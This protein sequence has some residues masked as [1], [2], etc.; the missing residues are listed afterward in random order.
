MEQTS[1]KESLKQSIIKFNNWVRNNKIPLSEA[2]VRHYELSNEFV[3]A[4]RKD[5]GYFPYSS[6]EITSLPSGLENYSMGAYHPVKYANLKEGEVVLD[7]GCG[8]GIDVFLAANRVGKSGKVIGVDVTF[9][10]LKRAK[11][12]ATG[13]YS[14]LTF[15]INASGDDLPVADRSVDAIISNGV[16]HLIQ[17]K[18]KAFTEF[19][20]VLRPHGRAVIS[21]V[22][23]E[24][25]IVG[26]FYENPT[27]Y[28]YSGGGKKRVEEY[29]KMAKA[30]GF[31]D[32]QFIEEKQPWDVSDEPMPGGYMILK[33]PPDTADCM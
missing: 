3:A 32:F 27:I 24:S 16:V 30:A 11:G 29:E 15:F 19:L 5:L 10:L 1:D 33:K 14:S 8:A 26:N 22:V 4:Q 7:V 21:D 17:D 12:Y 28:F 31:S 23:A 6:D 9:P 13:Q 20:R 25:E 18:P 2:V